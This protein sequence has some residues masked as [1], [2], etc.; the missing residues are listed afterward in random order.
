[1]LSEA[2][3]ARDFHTLDSLRNH[4]AVASFIAWVKRKPPDFSGRTRKSQRLR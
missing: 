1:L 2:E 3:L 4:P